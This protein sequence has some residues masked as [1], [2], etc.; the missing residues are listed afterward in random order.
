MGRFKMR[1]FTLVELAIVITVIGIL[2]AVTVVSYT[3][4]QARSRDA[5]RQ[6]DIKIITE[7]LELYYFDKG[8]YPNSTVYTPG[9]TAI[10]GSWSTTADGSW[11]NLSAI[12]APY[13]KLPTKPPGAVSTTPAIS[14]G[15][16]YDYFGF[17]NS[18]Y[19]GSSVGQGY[20]LT[21]RKEGAQVN[22]LK[23]TCSGTAVGPY[24]SASNFRVVRD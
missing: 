7:A 16:N 14:G 8:Y 21:H 13:F 10:N 17:S 9:S 1:G 23:G 12:L 6:A 4:S 5:G 19:C 22:T 3:G 18:T 20:I 11:A 15:N 24:A 2:A